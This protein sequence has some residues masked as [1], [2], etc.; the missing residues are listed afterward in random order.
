MHGKLLKKIQD[1]TEFLLGIPLN[2]FYSYI[3]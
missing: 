3:D 1:G 2:K